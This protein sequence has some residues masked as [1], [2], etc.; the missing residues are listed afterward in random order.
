MEW[1]D[2][3]VEFAEIHHSDADSIQIVMDQLNTHELVA[4]YQFF[5][6]VRAQSYPN[7]FDFQYTPNEEAGRP[8]QKSSL[9]SSSDGISTGLS[10]T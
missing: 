8:W 6:T 10:I 7:R 9:P 4:F 2:R 1:I 3:M 5:R